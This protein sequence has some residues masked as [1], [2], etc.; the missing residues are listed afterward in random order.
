MKF[1]C[2]G[3]EYFKPA[4]T[5]EHQCWCRH[6]E[7]PKGVLTRIRSDNPKACYTARRQLPSEV[8]KNEMDRIHKKYARSR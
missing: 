5:N 7:H 6:P 2:V 1:T 3:C 8:W 4:S